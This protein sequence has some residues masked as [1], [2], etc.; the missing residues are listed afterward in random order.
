MVPGQSRV[1]RPL[2]TAPRGA[3]L[4]R[5][6]WLLA[7]VVGLRALVLLFALEFSGLSHA[8]L[9]VACSLA[10]STHATD[11]DCDSDDPGHECPPGCPN[12]HCWHAGALSLPLGIE[13]GRRIVLRLTAQLGFVPVTSMPLGNADLDA[14]YRPPRAPLF[15]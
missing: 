14:V 13:P 6:S 5:R 8:A 7:C 9:D 2:L 1:L 15:T 11:D 3:R 10:G 4:A 12:C